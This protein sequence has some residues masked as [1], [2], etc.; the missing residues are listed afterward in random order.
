MSKIKI[1]GLKRIE[2]IEF[3]NETMPDFAGFVF[4]GTKRNI[5]FN[6]AAKFKTALDKKIKAVGVFVNEPLG[7]ITFLFKEGI[8]DMAQLHGDE[9]EDFI[10]ALKFQIDMPVI[11]AIRV[12]E[13]L[14][15]LK[16]KADFILFDSYNENQCGGSGQTFDWNFIKDINTPYFL[17]GGLN[18][19][20]I[21]IA[22]KELNPFC[23]DIS[24]GVE[25]D[26]N[27]DL[28]KI[29]EIIKIV[30]PQNRG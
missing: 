23:I 11:K 27:K 14:K 21:P 25:T 16:S 13:P 8:I 17:A 24:G 4:A 3:V 22:L 6:M 26:G 2:D 5:S 30:K 19:Q 15:D 18:A 9:D 10:D 1:C 20:N 7:N 12:K 29:R 28:E